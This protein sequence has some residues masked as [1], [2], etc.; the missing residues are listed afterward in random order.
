MLTY[1]V[2]DRG[3]RPYTRRI[4]IFLRLVEGPVVS[5][6]VHRTNEPIRG[7]GNGTREGALLAKDGGLVTCL[8]R[9]VPYLAPLYACCNNRG[10]HIALSVTPRVGRGTRS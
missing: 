1:L 8:A 3:H 2:P 6:L 5:T 4:L 9:F 7:R 10:M